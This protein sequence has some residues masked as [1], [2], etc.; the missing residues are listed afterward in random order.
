MQA[1]YYS[2]VQGRFTSADPLDPVLGKQGANHSEGAE[3]EFR[4]YLGQPQNWN[5]YVY[6]LN[7]PLKYIDPSGEA[8]TITARMNIVWER[9]TAQNGNQGFANED[10]ARKAAQKYIDY[11]KKAYGS[12]DIAFDISFTEGTA[13]RPNSTKDGE[14]QIDPSKK[15]E[16]ALNVFL[17]SRSPNA[18]GAAFGRA[19][20]DIFLNVRANGESRLAH[21]VAHPF[22]LRDGPGGYN[23]TYPGAEWDIDVKSLPG[24]YRGTIKEGEDWVDDYRNA[25]QTRCCVPSSEP[26]RG[27]NPVAYQVRRS[28][29]TFDILRVGARRFTG[30][31]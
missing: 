5:R 4:R 9:G 28:P 19:N 21:E 2:N 1:R 23:L 15:V 6:A 22:G 30:K 20:G 7:N 26:W 17:T 24:M 10:A 8:P 12:L 18:M 3:S 11:L 29:T 16:G 25:T 14:A 27:G 31:R 13:Y